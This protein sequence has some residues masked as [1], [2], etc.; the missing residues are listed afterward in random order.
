MWQRPCARF[1]ENCRC[2]LSV[3]EVCEPLTI[4]LVLSL[5][6]QALMICI[7]AALLFVL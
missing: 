4:S 3:I 5:P 7:D 2:C 1:L 6:C